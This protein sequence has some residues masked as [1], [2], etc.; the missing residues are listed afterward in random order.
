ALSSRNVR[1]TTKARAQAPVIR[2][3]MLLAKQSL[4]SGVD[5][6]A[7]LIDAV[8]N[9]LYTHAP[10]AEIDYLE[11]VCASS[12]LPQARVTQKSLITIAAFFGDVRLID[13]IE[14]VPSN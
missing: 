11:C 14:L 12:L 8:R 4:E 7:Q 1:L 5:S 10:L 9:H 3:A 2:E 6:S 13:N